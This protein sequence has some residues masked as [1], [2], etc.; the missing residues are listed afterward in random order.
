[1]DSEKNLQLVHNT[2]SESED[3]EYAVSK[4]SRLWLCLCAGSN[5]Y[6]SEMLPDLPMFI[7]HACKINLGTDS[8][9]SN[10]CLSILEELKIISM[11]YPQIELAELLKWSTLNGAEYL[12]INDVFGSFEKRK[13]PGINLIENADL[14][15]IRLK[16]ESRIRVISS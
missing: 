4:F 14:L 5:Q 12:K 9:A 8:L 2:V 6:I 3:I 10:T 11:C 1:M 13:R 16:E 15:N 7:R